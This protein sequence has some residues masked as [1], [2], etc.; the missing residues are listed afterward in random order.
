MAR[1]A[2]LK[3]LDM[4]FLTQL[5]QQLLLKK[6]EAANERELG[7]GVTHVISMNSYRA[8]FLPQKTLKRGI[9]LT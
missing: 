6:Q 3:Q 8:A 2:N 9:G 4:N 5:Q 7:N 1:L